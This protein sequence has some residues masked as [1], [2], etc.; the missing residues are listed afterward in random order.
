M[1]VVMQS[2]AKEFHSQTV[3]DMLKNIPDL[4]WTPDIP[5]KFRGLSEEHVRHS[6]IPKI[7]S[8]TNE[9]THLIG[10]APD[11]FSWIEEKPECI[12]VRDSD[13]CG[14]W[15]FSSVGPFSDNRCISGE[16]AKRVTYSEQYMISCDKGSDG[17]AGT[18]HISQ[19]QYFLQKIGVPTDKCVSYKQVTGKC[20]TSCDDKTPLVL[21]KSSK[22]EDV[23]TNEES[24]MVQII[25]ASE[26]QRLRD[27]G[28]FCFGLVSQ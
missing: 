22:F 2:F 14:S 1:F 4:T 25:I 16:D 27:A 7:G 8:F 11:S 28:S 20:P 18:Y 19:P 3:L 21:Y 12:L 9:K 5:E 15:A 6:F 10:A 13:S 17:C 24:I 23:C 26:D